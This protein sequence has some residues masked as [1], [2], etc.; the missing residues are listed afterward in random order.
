MRVAAFKK[1]PLRWAMLAFTILFLFASFSVDYYKGIFLTGIFLTG[2]II[3]TLISG[4]FR[5][6]L[7]GGLIQK[8]F[9]LTSF[10]LIIITVWSL[11]ST[12]WSKVPEDTIGSCGLYF[13][14]LFL[15]LLLKYDFAETTFRK[16]MAYTFLGLGFLVLGYLVLQHVI[17]VLQG[18]KIRRG[19]Y[20][21][22][23]ENANNLG[24]ISLMFLVVF[25]AA[26]KGAKGRVKRGILILISLL[27]LFGILVS[28]SRS[29]FMVT[30]LIM[31][32]VI[33]KFNFRYI[34]AFIAFGALI[35]VVPQ[36]QQRFFEIFSYESNVQRVKVW[37]VAMALIKEN[38]LLGV[39]ANAFQA[40][41]V[42][43]FNANPHMFNEYDIPV[44]WHAHNMFLRFFAEMGLPGFL[45]LL[46]LLWGTFR[47]M[48][49][50]VRQKEV[51][52]S[53]GRLMDGIYL[54]VVAFYASNMLDSF[55]I[56]P[57]PL[58]IFYFLLGFAGG[59]AKEYK[60]PS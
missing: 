45:A 27:S 51:R 52:L 29:I 59:L 48:H 32:L 53:H 42:E 35:L 57:K 56:S 38:P 23:I 46:L 44:I 3:Y 39:G 54:A 58:L 1:E 28:Q 49:H 41:Y 16:V 31:I 2:C 55:W 60:I 8:P 12:L 11:L 43:V 4:A 14:F 20:I 22:T 6:R 19:L 30:G 37:Q 17:G 21:S 13:A 36:T 50:L 18:V 33:W 47:M 15:Y 10:A 34:W 9:S 24:I 40:G 25:V 5:K 26:L 7:F